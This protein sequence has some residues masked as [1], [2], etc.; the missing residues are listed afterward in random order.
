MNQ[1]WRVYFYRAG[2]TTPYISCKVWSKSAVAAEDW[3]RD[4]FHLKPETTVKAEPAGEEKSPPKRA[5]TG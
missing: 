4:Y 5:R 2:E 1:W 3:A